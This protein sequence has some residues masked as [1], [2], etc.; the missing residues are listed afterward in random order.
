MGGQIQ[1]DPHDSHILEQIMPLSDLP[2]KLTERKA[3]VPCFRMEQLHAIA[4]M[5]MQFGNLYV[6]SRYSKYFMSA[7]NSFE[8]GRSLFPVPGAPDFPDGN[9]NA[10]TNIK[11]ILEPAMEYIDKHLAEKFTVQ[12]LASICGISP[13]YFSK[14]FIRENLYSV[15]EY[16]N[17]KR[18]E[19]AI[20][21]LQ[22]TTYSVR[23]IAEYLGYDDSGYFIKV[24]KKITGY[25]PLEYQSK[26]CY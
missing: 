12:K 9:R 17:R 23:Q 1:L 7:P 20:K 22:G 2:A 21:M 4:K 19:L 13:S 24:F 8:R 5:M 15:S 25:T 26:Y 11:A 3:E 16:C 14:L 18:V 10:G 6:Q